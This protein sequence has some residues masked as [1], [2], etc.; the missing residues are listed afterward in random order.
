MNPSDEIQP[1]VLRFQPVLRQ[2]SERAL[3]EFCEVNE[4]WQ[5]ELTSDGDLEILPL[6][7]AAHGQT[8]AKLIVH[9]GIWAEEDGTGIPFGPL[10]GFRLPNGALRAPDIAWVMHERW[11]ALSEEEREGF[12]PFCP[13]FVI[14]LRSY[15]DGIERLQAK[16]HEYIENGTQ[17]GWLIDPRKKKVYVYRP[18]LSVEELDE[19]ETLSGA[20]LLKGFVLP[21]AKFWQK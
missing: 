7:G 12:V 16:M 17:L 1:V 13:D 8:N 20:P 10:T 9:V 3:L 2:I 5:F 19:P 11:E 21:M 18:D 15:F 6:P 4:T 14:E